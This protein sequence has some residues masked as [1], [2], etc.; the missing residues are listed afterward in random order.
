MKKII[1]M[2]NYYIGFDDLEECFVGGSYD[3]LYENEHIDNLTI[4]WD[5][6]CWDSEKKYFNDCIEDLKKQYEKRYNTTI[7]HIVLCG[8][9]GLWQGSRV[10]GKIVEQDTYTLDNMGNVDNI[11]VNIEDNGTITIVGSHHDNSHYMNLYFLTENK[12][13]KVGYDLSD[14]KTY[15][16]IYNTCAPVRLT[17]KNS[18]YS[19]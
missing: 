2:E 15:E 16:K 11:E 18:Y 5:R 12:L 3:E 9:V 7:E 13:K 19:I 4:E 1:D 17:K 8:R 14:Y 6:E 10:G